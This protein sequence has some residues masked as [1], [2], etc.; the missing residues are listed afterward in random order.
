MAIAS[1]I[2]P[3]DPVPATI[4]YYNE[5]WCGFGNGNGP[6]VPTPPTQIW[7]RV[8]YFGM[9][10]FDSGLPTALGYTAATVNA[11]SG[12]RCRYDR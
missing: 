4:N 11:L 9:P 2:C 3:S 12:N 7:G 10:G 8:D 1:Y 5:Q 6:P